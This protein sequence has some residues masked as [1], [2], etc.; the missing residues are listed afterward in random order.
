MAGSKEH[1][2]VRQRLVAAAA[3]L[4]EGPDDERLHAHL[5]S[6]PDCA[7]QWQEQIETLAG[8]QGETDPEGERHI[9]AAMMARWDHVTSDLR[10]LERQA[11]RGHL[12]RCATCREELESLG[13]PPVL[14][15]VPSARSQTRSGRSFRA[16]L[17]WGV[18]VTAIAAMMAW[19]LVLPEPR[20]QNSEVL[21]WVAPVT[22]RSGGPQTLRLPATAT[23]FSLLATVPA[24]LDKRRPA[25]VQVVDPQGNILL[26]TLATSEQLDARTLS[27]VIRV[28][29]KVFPGDY[30]VVFSQAGGDGQVQSWE[31]IFLVQRTEP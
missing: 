21:P 18:G 17:T 25:S 31:T 13:F 27:M 7:R 9:P 28:E 20:P 1:I 8:H 29:A 4:L 30:R 24:E 10:G 5:K 11:V 22:L 26:E 3:G 14:G 15:A 19:W 2:W 12:E 16:G 23:A 6:C